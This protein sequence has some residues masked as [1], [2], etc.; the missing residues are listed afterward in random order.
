MEQ[1]N[2]EIENRNIDAIQEDLAN[3][4][5]QRTNALY[6]AGANIAG[7][8]R[9]YKA[10]E[11]NQIIANNIGTSNWKY[12]KATNTIVYRTPEGQTVKVPVQ[13]AVAE[14]TQPAAQTTQPNAPAQPAAN[15]ANPL[16]LTGWGNPFKPAAPTPGPVKPPTP[17][18]GPMSNYLNNNQVPDYTKPPTATLREEDNSSFYG[19]NNYEHQSDYVKPPE[20]TDKETIKAFQDWLD[21]YHPDEWTKSGKPLKKGKGYGNFGEQT[22]DAWYTYGK[23]F[24]GKV[25]FDNRR[26]SI[27]IDEYYS[28]QDYYDSLP[29]SG[30]YNNSWKNVPG[31]PQKPKV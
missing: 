14:T 23:E 5:T 15:K 7:M 20:K 16:G 4:Q 17:Y 22:D 19:S 27:P 28:N 3:F 1:Q 26:E 30:L 29:L 6:N 24:M 31:F 18:T 25:P 8:R 21:L 12:D 9:D 10:N 11:I 13:T 2:T